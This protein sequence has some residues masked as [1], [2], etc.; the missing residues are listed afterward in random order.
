MENLRISTMTAVSKLS[1]DINLENL[2]NNLEIN[3]II[4]FIEYKE[5]HKGYSKKLDKKC[6]KKKEKK[7]FYNQATIHIYHTNKVINIK[8]FN[9]GKIQMTGLKYEDQGKEVPRYCVPNYG[10]RDYSSL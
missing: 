10:R 9:N 6:R 7:T 1:S 2:Y 8:I 5:K 3:N 4:K